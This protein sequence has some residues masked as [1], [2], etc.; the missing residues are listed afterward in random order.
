MKTAVI[1]A[2]A[3]AVAVCAAVGCYAYADGEALRKRIRELLMKTIP[4]LESSGARYFLAFGTLLG[5]VRDGDVIKG[6]TDGDI[7]VLASDAKMV[8][9]VASKFRRAG[10][11]LEVCG[12]H[13]MRLRDS[14]VP[15]VYV[16]LYMLDENKKTQM[17][18][19]ALWG[20]K[21]KAVVFPT[22]LV[23]PLCDTTFLG[24]R[25]M[26]PH[27][28]ELLLE[29]IYGSSWRIPKRHCKGVHSSLSSDRLMGVANVF[30]LGLAQLIIGK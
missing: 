16:D 11:L 22:E 18:G 14:R 17:L 6:D 10:V 7:G 26:I 1:T 21:D 29:Y 25:T 23:L 24:V 13:L 30:A 3:G 28:S 9:A 20:N 12:K 27:N 8:L 19:S 5:H 2:S 4:I 15:Y